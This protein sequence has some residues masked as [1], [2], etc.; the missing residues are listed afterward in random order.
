MITRGIIIV[1]A[2]STASPRVLYD[3][4][5]LPTTRVL[6]EKAYI[7]IGLGRK[8]GS[9]VLPARPSRISYIVAHGEGVEVPISGD[10]RSSP[11]GPVAGTLS[12]NS[13]TPSTGVDS[14]RLSAFTIRS[15]TH[16]THKRR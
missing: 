8:K 1:A 13:L 3:S 16:T 12:P 15:E 11:E 9:L 10:P 14:C 6:D 7:R 4:W 2:R 5:L